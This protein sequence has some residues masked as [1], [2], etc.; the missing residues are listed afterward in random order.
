MGRRCR[1]IG[2]TIERKIEVLFCHWNFSGCMGIIT[3]VS[4]QSQPSLM[5]PRSRMGCHLESDK[6]NGIGL[7]CWRKQETRAAQL[8]FHSD[9]TLLSMFIIYYLVV[10]FSMSPVRY[11]RLGHSFSVSH[12]LFCSGILGPPKPARVT[13]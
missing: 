2:R 8:T 6:V 4:L 5:L 9:L 3:C 10:Y 11:C 1:K 7:H 13:S 12:A